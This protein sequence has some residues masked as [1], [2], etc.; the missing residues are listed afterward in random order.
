M[1]GYS[2]SQIALFLR[3]DPNWQPP[4]EENH[5]RFVCDE[6][7]YCR[8]YC[9]MCSRIVLNLKYNREWSFSSSNGIPHS[10]NNDEKTCYNNA[11]IFSIPQETHSLS[12]TLNSPKSLK[13]QTI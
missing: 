4:V 10:N 13:R 7:S 3:I 5:F 2:D 9:T 8:C 1:A 6:L 11:C 12:S